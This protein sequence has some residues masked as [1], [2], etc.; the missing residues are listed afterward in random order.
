MFPNKK[1]GVIWIE[2][3]YNE[4]DANSLS[5]TSGKDADLTGILGTALNDDGMLLPNENNKVELTGKYL[6][7]NGER[8]PN[9]IFQKYKR[10]LEEESGIELNKNSKLQFNIEGKTPKRRYRTF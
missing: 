7:I 8:Q 5:K 2:K 3:L 4:N 1:D 9:N 6:K 10:I